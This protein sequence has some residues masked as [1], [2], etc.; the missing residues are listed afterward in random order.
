MIEIFS[1]NWK[2]MTEAE[3]GGFLPPD[4]YAADLADGRWALL[5]IDGAKI[6]VE[7]YSAEIK[8]AWEGEER[9]LIDYY[10]FILSAGG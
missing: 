10:D 6:H 5:T 3:R 7:V 1:A 4:S 8:D 2:P 9:E